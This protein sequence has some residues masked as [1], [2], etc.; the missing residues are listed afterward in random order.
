MTHAFGCCSTASVPI[1]HDVFYFTKVA[2]TVRLRPRSI[3]RTKFTLVWEPFFV[4]DHEVLPNASIVHGIL[5]YT[6]PHMRATTSFEYHNSKNA[7]RLC[8]KRDTV[9]ST[10]QTYEASG[11]QFPNQFAQI[12][13]RAWFI[14]TPWTDTREASPSRSS[15]TCKKNI[16]L[17]SLISFACSKFNPVATHI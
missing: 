14:P 8:N 1:I 3:Q 17:V 4:L 7:A 5:H 12:R 2:I 11:A 13:I 6:C 15:D 16:V 9:L 10:H